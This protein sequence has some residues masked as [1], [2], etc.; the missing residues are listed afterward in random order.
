MNRQLAN[1]TIK[2]HELAGASP[3]KPLINNAFSFAAKTVVLSARS[4][5]GIPKTLLQQTGNWVLQVEMLTLKGGTYARRFCLGAWGAFTINV[6][7]FS[8]LSVFLLEDG[9]SDF[10]LVIEIS[11][12]QEASS[13]PPLLYAQILPAPGSYTVPWGAYELFPAQNDPG[14]AWKIEGLGG[15]MI[16]PVAAATGVKMDVLGTYFETKV[17]PFN[18]VWRIRV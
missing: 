15:P 17:F 7:P 13:Q 3:N 16:V 12:G 4:K 11:D 18:T 8:S 2:A 9:L 10:D 6:E 5:A 1:Y 14:F